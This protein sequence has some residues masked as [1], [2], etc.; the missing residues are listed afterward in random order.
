[1]KTKKDLIIP[2]TWDERRPAF[3]ERF[4]YLPK[5]L[6]HRELRIDW[7][8]PEVFGNS[9]PVCIELCSGNGQW[10]GER[11]KER[12][13]LN[14]VA[15]DHDFGR[16]RKIWLKAFRENIP[17]LYPVCA[18]GTVFLRHYVRPKSVM[19]S[20]VNFPDPWP[21]LRHAKH[22]I[23]QKPF[24]DALSTALQ[25]GGMATFVTDDASYKDQMIRELGRAPWIP[26]LPAPHYHTDW[27]AYGD[28]Y[29]ANLWQKRGR[30]I[31][32]VQHRNG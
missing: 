3:L 32:Y 14:W 5:K 29:F 2:F 18:E 28:S 7:A 15:V 11:A 12:P 31:Y 17:N 27:S 30:T 25:D 19:Q 16:A 13:D 9:N 10:V 26:V 4:F 6:E 21:K 1:M 8:A 22:R 20:F 23:I 24:L